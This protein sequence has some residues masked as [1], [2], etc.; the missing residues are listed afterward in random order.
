[1]ADLSSQ[2]SVGSLVETILKDGYR[3]DILLNCA[4]IQRRHQ[5]HTFP[6]DDWNEVCGKADIG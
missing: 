6:N 3:I 1:M 5:S 2:E 4:G